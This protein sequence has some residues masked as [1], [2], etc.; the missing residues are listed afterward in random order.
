MLREFLPR[1]EGAAGL[2]R[3]ALHDDRANKAQVGLVRA[4]A[5][6]GVTVGEALDRGLDVVTDLLPHVHENLL[7]ERDDVFLIREAHLDVELREL[8]L[9]IRA[10]VFIAV[11]AGELEVAFH[12]AHHQQLLEQLRRLGKRVPRSLR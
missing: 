3:A 1:V 9:A 10:E 11:A 4:V 6:H 2:R 12:T 5:R 8:R 7:G